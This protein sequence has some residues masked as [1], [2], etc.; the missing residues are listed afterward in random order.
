MKIFKNILVIIKTSK[1]KYLIDKYGI[2]SC[3]SSFEYPMLKQSID[4]H[5]KNCDKFI[6]SI[7]KV[8]SQDQKIHIVNDNFLDNNIISNQINSND[9]DLI[10]S[11]G[12]DGTLL[13]SAY[14]INKCNQVLI[15][16]NTDNKNS[17]GFYCPLHAESCIDINNMKKLLNSDF[18][19]R[20]MNKLSISIGDRNYYFMN[21]LYLGE[22]FMGRVSKY[23]LTVNSDQ[24]S[25]I[26]SSGI[27]ISTFSGYSGWIQNA[28]TISYPKFSDLITSNLGIPILNTQEKI[29]M[30]SQNKFYMPKFDTKDDSIFYFIREANVKPFK[31]SIGIKEYEK[32]LNFMEG[33]AKCLEIQ[34]FCY[35]GNLI[36]DGSFTIPVD[37]NEKIKIS[38]GEKKIITFDKFNSGERQRHTPIL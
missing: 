7:N 9:Y 34:N 3:K 21:D 14:F 10:F 30:Y 20:K 23:K 35:E 38:L 25:I 12:G 28:N 22:K 1:L 2:D 37:Y 13:R 26:K 29:N 4:V 17:T 27:I 8:K 24:S 5:S 15:G 19:T 6:E 31:D 36:V 33:S 16:V 32:Y 18:Q 11:L